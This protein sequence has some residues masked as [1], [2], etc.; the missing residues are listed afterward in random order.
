MKK[1]VRITS[2]LILLAMMFS[3]SNGLNLDESYSS[4]NSTVVEKDDI[5]LVKINSKI[6]MRAVYTPDTDVYKDYTFVLSGYY[7]DASSLTKI[8]EWPDY[9]SMINSE[10]VVKQGKWRFILTAN[11]ADFIDE[12]SETPYIVPVLSGEYSKTLK[13]SDTL[14]FDLKEIEDCDLNGYY[15][16]TLNYPKSDYW[17]IQAFV[18]DPATL[19]TLDY[20]PTVVQSDDSVNIYGELPSGNYR[21][22]VKFVYNSPTLDFA[23]PSKI[24]LFFRIAPGCMTTGKETVS[25]KQLNMQIPIIYAGYDNKEYSLPSGYPKSFAPTEGLKL[26][27]A[28]LDGYEF[29]Y[30]YTTEDFTNLT[31]VTTTP[32]YDDVSL[33][34]ELVVYPRFVKTS[35]EEFS[36]DTEDGTENKGVTFVLSDKT[37]A[38]NKDP[39]GSYEFCIRNTETLDIYRN[40]FYVRDVQ[41][42]GYKYNFPFVEPGTEY[43]FWVDINGS[44]NSTDVLT[45]IPTSGD[46]EER[47]NSGNPE[48]ILGDDGILHVTGLRELNESYITGKCYEFQLYY[49]GW[50]GYIDQKNF[51]EAPDGKVDIDL[52]DFLSKY[53]LYEKNFILHAYSWIQYGNYRYQMLFGDSVLKCGKDVQN[54]VSNI[55]IPGAQISYI[56]ASATERGIQ[57]ETT[58]VEGTAITF[59]VENKES[60]VAA[61]RDWKKTGGWT[62]CTVMYPFV[63]SGKEYTFT[64]KVSETDHTLYQGDFTITA[65]GGIGEFKIENANDYTVELTNDRVIQL[66]DQPV[67]TENE[68]VRILNQAEDLALYKVKGNEWGE[69]IYGQTS[70][71]DETNGTLSLLDDSDGI[72]KWKSEDVMNSTMSGYKY[73]LT[74]NTYIKIA[75]YTDNGQT[76]FKM[77]DWKDVLGAWGGDVKKVYIVYGNYNVENPPEILDLP[78]EPVEF[79]MTTNKGEEKYTC[80]AIVVDYGTTIYEPN[81]NPHYSNAKKSVF[82]Y[83]TN[84]WNSRINFPYTVTPV[85]EKREGESTLNIT[86]DGEIVE[87]LDYFIPNITATFT[88]TLMSEGKE[89]GTEDFTVRETENGIVGTSL[90]TTPAVEDGKIFTGWYSDEEC[91]KSFNSNVYNNVTVYAGILDGELLWDSNGETYYSVTL[92]S[93]VTKDISPDDT[94]YVEV[95]YSASS[96]SMAETSLYVGNASIDFSITGGETKLIACS[97]KNWNQG[98]IIRNNDYYAS[99]KRIYIQKCTRLNVNVYNGTTLL[100]TVKVTASQ[101]VYPG[102]VSVDNYIIEGLYTDSTFENEWNGYTSEDINVY[103]KVK[104]TETLWTGYTND[105][106]IEI[107]SLKLSDFEVGDTLYFTVYNTLTRE[108]DEGNFKFDAGNGYNPHSV[109]IDSFGPQETKIIPYQ[110]TEDDSSFIESIKMYGLGIND[111]WNWYV[112]RVDYVSINAKLGFEGLYFNDDAGETM[113]FS[114]NNRTV[115]LSDGEVKYVVDSTDPTIFRF[116]VGTEIKQTYQYTQ[117]DSDTLVLT[118]LDDEGVTQESTTWKKKKVTISFMD[119]EDVIN[120]VSAYVGTSVSSFDVPTKEGY[121]F[122]GWYADSELTSKV[123]EVQNDVTTLYAGW[124]EM[125]TIFDPAYYKGSEGEVVTIDGE[126]YLKV[127]TDGYSTSVSLDAVLDVSDYSRIIGKVFC[128]KSSVSYTVCLQFQYN[129]Q[130]AAAFNNISPK[131][132]PETYKSVCGKAFTWQDW[133][134]GGKETVG[135]TEMEHISIF[136]QD[137]TDWSALNDIV[138]YIGKIT[139]E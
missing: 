130:Q 114:A 75:G 63:E 119:G 102:A 98:D 124:C 72:S 21:I 50:N 69:W 122:N 116:V 73:R 104:E 56:T 103:A 136:A 87:Y 82:N 111:I 8:K 60:G 125:K 62:A 91:T 52:N 6:P 51:D 42:Y 94:M 17:N 46:G 93:S 123:Y 74:A 12:E 29:K 11:K 47:F 3:C 99:I 88:A 138:I 112:T 78:G 31:K 84:R 41:G 49:E 59:S 36:L 86:V 38:A 19:K 58:V 14:S 100:Q 70:W 80:N 89:I 24:P 120:T 5:V 48:F 96:N 71:F 67:F 77:N 53:K 23:S 10:F 15:N 54:Y 55:T 7:N 4:D 105:G 44:G 97:L 64:V 22:N 135:V 113:R 26:P 121:K 27:D 76:Y 118:E 126:K 32:I 107:D 133:S 34:T 129:G 132:E 134:N 1:M 117:P 57:F 79:T 109:Y 137:S 61:I 43:E 66:T 92:N 108:K 37:I 25:F 101:K 35:S 18:T 139:A 16:F 40:W 28:S 65:T 83:W 90:T 95:Y 85:T 39:E 13:E 128:E 30:W 115:Y 20:N 106:K 45:V 33:A 131:A 127:I 2:L 68:N 81:S 9:N 110:F